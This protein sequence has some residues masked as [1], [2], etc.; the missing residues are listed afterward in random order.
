MRQCHQFID[1]GTPFLCVQRAE[2]AKGLL[3]IVIDR[4]GWVHGAGSI[5]KDCLDAAALL[6]P[7]VKFPTGNILSVNLDVAGSRFFQPDNQPGQRTLS[8]A[9]LSN[10]RKIF[11]LAPFKAHLIER[12][13]WIT[14]YIKILLGNL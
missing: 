8:G 6:P 3:H 2:I 10:H 13:E 14:F 7:A 9:A 12:Q 5:L 4:I 1:P 11:S